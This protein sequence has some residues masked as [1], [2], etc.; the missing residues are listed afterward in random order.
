[1]GNSGKSRGAFTRHD[2]T[3]TTLHAL[4][5]KHLDTFLRFAGER[6]GRAP[7]RYVVEEFRAYLRCGVLAHGFA[8]ARCPTCGHD[9]FVAFSCKLR[10]I[11]PSCGGRRMSETAAKLVDRVLPAVP[12]RQWVLSVPFELRVMLAADPTTLTLTA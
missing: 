3:Q 4:V 12:V 8:R 7:P 2:P 5:A 1:M 10:E 11:C 9:L 6:S